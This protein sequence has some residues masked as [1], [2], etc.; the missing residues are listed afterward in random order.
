MK[1]LLIVDIQNDFM[2]NGALGVEDASSIISKINQIMPFFELIVA[3]K[4]WHPDNHVSF[5]KTHQKQPGDV[6][7]NL[8]LWPDHCVQNTFGS[9]F[10]KDLQSANIDKIFFKGSSAF[11]ES[12]SGFYT[13][14]GISNGLHEYLQEKGVKEVFIVGIALEYCVNATALDAESLGYR[15]NVIKEAVAAIDRSKKFEFLEM[16]KNKGVSCLSINEIVNK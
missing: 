16:F 12:F 13:S 9:E 11:E 3:T 4:D 7:Q 6:L 1:A 14:P 5:A 8:I 15:A 10:P 2:P